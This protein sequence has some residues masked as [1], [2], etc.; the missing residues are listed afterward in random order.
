MEV[1]EDQNL[2]ALSFLILRVYFLIGSD[3]RVGEKIQ[4]PT[5][6]PGLALLHP[7]YFCSHFYLLP[8]QSHTPSNLVV[9]YWTAD[10]ESN[11]PLDFL[12]R[13]ALETPFGRLMICK[14]MSI[15]LMTCDFT[16]KS[17]GI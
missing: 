14:I 11:A 6:S 16:T 8:Q 4:L 2:L 3:G 5:L 10:V 1:P 12:L 7:F 9:A 17:G 13:H 15:V